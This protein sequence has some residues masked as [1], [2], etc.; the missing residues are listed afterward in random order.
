MWFDC[1][2]N[3]WA[4]W[5]QESSSLPTLWWCSQGW[6][7]SWLLLLIVVCWPSTSN[8]QHTSYIDISCGSRFWVWLKAFFHMLHLTSI[9]STAL[10]SWPPQSWTEVRLFDSQIFL[11]Y[12][13][14]ES[15]FCEKQKLPDGVRLRGDINVLLLGDPSTAKSQVKYLTQQY[16]AG[17]VDSPIHLSLLQGSI[18]KMS[19]KYISIY[20][21]ILSLLPVWGFRYSNYELN[22]HNRYHFDIMDMQ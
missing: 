19:S 10:L 20:W 4:W 2:F 7:L 6:F 18:L 3:F 11:D 14:I 17:S 12:F 13:D 15:C 8:E 16:P 21:I 22:L 5:C 1:S 9:H